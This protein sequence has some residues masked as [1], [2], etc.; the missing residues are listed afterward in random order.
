M[1][2]KVTAKTAK[3]R[4][5]HLVIMLLADAALTRLSP[6]LSPFGD[7]PQAG[8]RSP[9]EERRID[10]ALGAGSRVDTALTG[11]SGIGSENG[12]AM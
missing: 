6:I 3:D 8:R 12:R 11:F 5:N 2:A 1:T 7:S 4:H 9:A 10:I